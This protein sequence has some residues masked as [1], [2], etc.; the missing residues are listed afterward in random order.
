[1]DKLTPFIRIALY[2]LAGRLAAAG[3]PPQAV[4]IVGN[5][6]IV[7]EVASLAVVGVVMLW[8]RLAKRMG[9]ST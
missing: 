3:L 4:D 6:P 2:Y 5:D 7:L 8:W 9:W 1:M